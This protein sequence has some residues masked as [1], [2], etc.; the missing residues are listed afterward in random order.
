V[1]AGMK[2]V[3]LLF[4]A[5]LRDITGERKMVK[6]IPEDIL[7]SGLKELLVEEYP[8]LKKIMASVIVSLNHEFAFDNASIPSDA[9]I[10]L[11]P[12]VSGG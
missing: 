3:T 11:F 8:G 10:A 12:P 5:T 4:F 1:E 7:I 9:E 2:Q 6:M